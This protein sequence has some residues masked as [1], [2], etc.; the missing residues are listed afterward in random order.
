VRRHLDAVAGWFSL[1]GMDEF[2]NERMREHAAQAEQHAAEAVNEAARILANARR[3]ADA[4]RQAARVEAATMLEEARRE[5][6]RQRR[7][8]SRVGR[9]VGARFNGR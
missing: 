1:A 6:A 3:E 8:W 5:A 9:P 2:L 7:G 4:I